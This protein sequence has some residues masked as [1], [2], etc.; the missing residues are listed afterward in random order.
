MFHPTHP[1]PGPEFSISSHLVLSNAPCP[2]QRTI[3][4]ESHD[5]IA[6]GCG[7]PSDQTHKPICQRLNWRSMGTPIAKATASA[8]T[9]TERE[10]HPAYIRGLNESRLTSSVPKGVLHSRVFEQV[11]RVNFQ[12]VIGRNPESRGGGTG[13]SQQDP[14]NAI[15]AIGFFIKRRV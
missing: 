10:T 11:C 15:S 14:T 7:Q 5:T 3:I 12:A 4:E 2:K 6:H 13:Q 1:P 9:A 8:P